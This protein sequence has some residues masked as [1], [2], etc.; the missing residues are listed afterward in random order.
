MV[1]K[2][3]GSEE[4]KLASHKVD[5]WFDHKPAWSPDGTVIA[6]PLGSEEGGQH[7]TVVTVSV[8]G[9]VEKHF[10]QKRWNEV[11]R[12]E[13]LPGG[14]SLLVQ[15]TEGPSPITQIFQL[16]YPG[17]EATRITN[18]LLDY[19]SL[20]L[21][22]DAQILCVVQGDMRGNIL[23][24][25]G[26]SAAHAQ[27]I[28]SGRDEGLPGLAWTPDGRIVHTSSAS[29]SY[30]LWV[31]DPNGKNRRQL[32]ADAA[33]DFDPVVS[34][35]GKFILFNTDRSGIFNIWRIDIDG[36]KARQLTGPGESYS[37]SISSDGSW[38][39]FVTWA[40][41]PPLIMK[42]STAGGEPV[43][44]SET[45]GFNP[46]ISPDG[47]LVAYQYL[48]EQTRNRR[49]E[50][51]RA[52]GG[53]PLKEFELPQMARNAL[54]WSRDGQAVQYIVNAG[55]SSNVWSQPLSGGPP[56][57]VTE[58][59]SDYLSEFDWSP[60]GKLLAVSRYSYSGDVVLMSN[61][62]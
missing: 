32:T 45:N 34:P 31:M 16:S 9:G 23:V 2:T 46:S 52:E 24:L 38:F 48:D 50:I 12:L 47:T 62:K 44:L 55:G 41:G 43:Q 27:Q 28:T 54:R 14:G 42:E 57:Q 49:I 1:A 10:T 13:W 36:S 59:T 11:T 17:G 53:K 19:S 18:D 6:C 25:P 58:F 22:H 7:F 56:K 35:D 33:F 29:G 3:D 4:R 26:G 15:A 5:L 21:S 40:K 61:P 8:D 39:V 60:D 20:S 51:I 37:P 30:D